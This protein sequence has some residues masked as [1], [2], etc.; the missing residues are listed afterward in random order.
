MTL[1]SV[2]DVTHRYPITVSEIPVL[3]RVNLEV[4]EGSVVAVVGESGC[5]KTSLGRVIVGLVRPLEGEVRYEGKDIWDLSKKE[6]AA[7][8]RAVQVVHQDPYASLNPGLTVEETLKTGLLY[9]HIVTRRTARSELFRLLES[10]GLEAT[11]AFLRRYPH[12]LSGGQRQRLVIARTMGL[13]PRLVV[14]DEA[15]S[16]LDVSMRVAVLDLLLSM[17]SELNL[18]YVF[19]SHDFGVV[20]YFARGGRIVVMFFGVVVEEGPAEQLIRHPRHPYTFLLLDAVPVPDPKVARRR[21]TEATK[22]AAER[23]TG[24]PS[25]TGCV[26]SN[27]CPYAEDKCRVD[28]PPLVDSGPQH[29][30]RVACW[31]PDKVPDLQA[32]L[33]ASAEGRA[34]PEGAVLSG[35]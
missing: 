35:R 17:R 14:A 20:R 10:V 31:F 11:P 26:F 2:S 5:G 16:M 7:Y 32:V 12:Q 15:V 25:A 21:R 18:A 9:H 30:H 3:N 13:R 28:T 34:M 1:L 4:E 22:V 33:G 23:V 19:I 29:G 27:R 6:H 24:E 8:R